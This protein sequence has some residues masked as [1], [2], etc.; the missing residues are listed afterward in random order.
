MVYLQFFSDYTEHPLWLRGPAWDDVG[1][2]D[3][4]ELGLSAP[5]Q[6]DLA[7][8]CNREDGDD[9][10]RDGLLG[11]LV[12]ALDLARRVQ[13]ELG[14]E[15]EVWRCESGRH[16]LLLALPGEGADLLRFEAGRPVRLPIRTLAVSV[17]TRRRIHRWRAQ[18]RH[19]DGLPG[20]ASWRAEGLSIAAAIQE[21]VGLDAVV[22]YRGGR[23]EEPPRAPVPPWL[24]GGQWR[25]Y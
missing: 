6:E 2:A 7:D 16:E 3:A 15:H 25:A 14:G 13:L 12:R 22:G 20:D 10:L 24:R 18:R 5:L 17:P 21:E 8:W 19:A 9:Q 1:H 23:T 4:D 11:H